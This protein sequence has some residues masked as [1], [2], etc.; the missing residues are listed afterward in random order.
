M[1]NA[2]PSQHFDRSDLCFLGIDRQHSLGS[3]V[4]AAESTPSVRA[5]FHCDDWVLS[6]FAA[7]AAFTRT[8]GA[9]YSGESRGT[10][11]AVPCSQGNYC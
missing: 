8:R 5:F 1:S 9:A 3:P 11:A 2:K 10:S 6:D 4:L 7:I